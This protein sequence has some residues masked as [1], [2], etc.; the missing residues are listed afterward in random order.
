MTLNEITVAALQQLKRGTDSQTIDGYRGTFTQYANMAQQD[1]AK[2]FPLYR[3]DKVRLRNGSFDVMDML[4][5]CVKVIAVEAAGKPAAYRADG[6][7]GR[8]VVETQEQDVEVRYRCLPRH[9]ENP[10]DIT[11]LPAQLHP[12]IVSYVVACDRSAGDSSTQGGAS[13]YFQLYNDQKRKLMR[14]SYGIPESYN[15]ENL[16]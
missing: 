4:R 5:W 2:S 14:G 15:I 16:F 6:R 7:T 1:L 13:L 3:T 8:V 12:C 9:L 10:T 11:E